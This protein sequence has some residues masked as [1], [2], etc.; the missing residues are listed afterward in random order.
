MT[1]TEIEPLSIGKQIENALSEG[2]TAKELIAKGFNKGSVH[3]VA[4]LV[5]HG[6][7]KNSRRREVAPSPDE[8]DNLIKNCVDEDFW[9]LSIREQI[10][11]LV[12]MNVPRNVLIQAGYN[13]GS[14][15]TIA[16][17]IKRGKIRDKK[18]DSVN[19]VG[20][21]ITTCEPTLIKR[22]FVSESHLRDVLCQDVSIIE[23][24]LVL[25]DS[26]YLLPSGKRI[27]ILAKEL[28][29][30]LVVIE[31]KKSSS[32]YSVMGQISLYMNSVDDALGSTLPCRGIIIANEVTEELKMAC[33][34]TARIKLVEYTTYLELKEV[35]K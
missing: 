32:V 9:T 15:S 7:T 30:R 20:S 1:I 17:M 4:S 22:R 27:D 24:G 3:T 13:K 25:V 29:G 19:K 34:G 33:R 31:I 21:T 16:S 28:G 8:V 5:R 26:E 2:I 35:D 14:I 11:R 18:V 23:P 12:F 10:A 6:K